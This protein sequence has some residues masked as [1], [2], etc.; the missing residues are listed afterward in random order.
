MHGVR[1]ANARGP[2]IGK[3]YS[4]LAFYLVFWWF[5]YPIVWGL[6]E[7]GNR[8]SSTAEASPRRKTLS[9]HKHVANSLR[10]ESVPVVLSAPSC[11]DSDEACF[12]YPVVRKA[13]VLLGCSV[14]AAARCCLV[15]CE[16]L[17]MHSIL[18][19]GLLLCSPGHSHQGRLRLDH[20]AVAQHPG[21]PV[22]SRARVSS[23]VCK[24]SCHHG[25][26]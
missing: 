11:L 20:H 16:S 4:F 5:G 3:L 24:Q 19:A 9:N 10:V 13:I 15:A 25:P 26:L 23:T 1:G 8:I 7:G 22:R 21:P 18:C 2:A 6:A 17:S 14:F 12:S